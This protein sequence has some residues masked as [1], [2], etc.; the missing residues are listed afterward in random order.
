MRY[1]HEQSWITSRVSKEK[2]KGR[3]YKIYQMARPMHEIEASI[4]NKDTDEAGKKL[5]VTQKLQKT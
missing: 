2:I 1:L 3:P 4:E 5:A